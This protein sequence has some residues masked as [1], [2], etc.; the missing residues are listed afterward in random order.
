MY[1]ILIVQLSLLF[2][3]LLT[4]VG[5]VAI[6]SVALVAAG[7][8]TLFFVGL[9]HIW[10][11]IANRTRFWSLCDIHAASLLISYF[12]GSAVTLSLSEGGI[13]SSLT[14]T[15]LATIFD[16][17]MFIVVFVLCLYAFGRI[18]APFWRRLFE[19][20]LGSDWP[21]WVPFLLLAL[22]GLQAALIASGAITFQ[23]TGTEEGDVLPVLA[24]LIVALSWPLMG[25]CGWILGQPYLRKRRLFLMSALALLP[26][27]LIFSFAHGRRVI[28]FQALIFV[29]C[30]AWSRGRGLRASQLVMMG[31]GALPII[32]LLWVI[33]LA[34]RIEGYSY[35][36]H[37][38]DTRDILTRLE[39]A[40]ELLGSRWQT[41]AQSQE[42]E[43]VD[44]VF[45]LGYLVD[46]MDNARVTNQYF[47]R[48]LLG[49]MLTGVPR[50]LLP[51]KERI[52]AELRSREADVG[53]RY[54]IGITDRATSIVTASYVD[55]RWLGPPIFAALAFM[56]GASMA[57]LALLIRMNFFSVYVI[58]YVFLAALATETTFFAHKFNMMR[59]V[60]VFFIA[61][62]LY[63][64]LVRLLA[65]SP[66]AYRQPRLS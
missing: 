42:D 51:D 21:G 14:I 66:L 53:Q 41:V 9:A 8:L 36:R 65:G 22:G 59:L 11:I 5:A 19:Q 7:H 25:I 3:G 4:V 24:S 45:V 64:F 47:G 46:L 56:V 1:L 62:C 15:Q 63:Q 55:F 2:V 17:S 39:S 6:D 37:G 29:T 35:A 10:V 44:R 61:L 20:D 57:M 60:V 50:F 40:S 26:I 52:L 58:S 16:A 34:L 32:Y 30:F 49:E 28:L 23:G 27:E 54:N 38:N 12:G 31:V 48:V 13:I 33:F 18:E 43:V